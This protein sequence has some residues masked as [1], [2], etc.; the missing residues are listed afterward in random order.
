[1]FEKTNWKPWEHDRLKPSAF[2]RTF[3]LRNWFA[4]LE[5]ILTTLWSFDVRLFIYVEGTEIIS[6]FWPEFDLNV[7]KHLHSLG[8]WTYIHN[9]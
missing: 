5:E 1:M 2:A 4:Y 6:E 9:I 8:F 7:S 3:K